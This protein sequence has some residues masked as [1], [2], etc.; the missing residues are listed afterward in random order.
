MTNIGLRYTR[1]VV[2]IMCN[3]EEQFA[4]MIYEKAMSGVKIN[5]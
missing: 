2:Q 1:Y 5:Y 3:Y 4:L